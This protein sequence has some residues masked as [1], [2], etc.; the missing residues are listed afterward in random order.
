MGDQSQDP[1]DLL[2][3]EACVALHM[4]A[5]IGEVWTRIIHM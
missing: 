2:G 3:S 5:N 4:V 1:T